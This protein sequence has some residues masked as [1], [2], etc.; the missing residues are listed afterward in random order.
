MVKI[1]LP[2]ALC[3]RA[4]LKRLF[5]AHAASWHGAGRAGVDCHH[6]SRAQRGWD[7]AFPLEELVQCVS[8]CDITEPNAEAVE[9]YVTCPRSSTWKERSWVCCL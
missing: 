5:P 4:C 3:S 2:Q 9:A 8:L 6:R 7:R 1:W